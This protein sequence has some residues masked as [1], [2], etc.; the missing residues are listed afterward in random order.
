MPDQDY[1]GADHR[2]PG[3]DGEDRADLVGLGEKG[4]AEEEHEKQ[5]GHAW[6]WYPRRGHDGS[7]VRWGETRR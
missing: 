6:E 1:H 2:A 7:G 4:E 3:G 5:D